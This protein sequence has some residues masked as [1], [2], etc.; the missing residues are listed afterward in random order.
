[1]SKSKRRRHSEEFK[2][3]AVKLVTE[4][5]YSVAKAARNLGVHVNLLRTWQRKFAA[6]ATEEQDLTEEER[7][8][9]A[10]LRTENKRL[11]MERDILKK[12]NGLLRERE[13]LRF[14]FIE[15][16]CEEWP[17]TVMCK[18]LEVSR[19]GFSAWRKRA[20]SR[21][22]ERQRTW[23]SEMQQIHSDRDMKSY[24]S[25]RMQQELVARGDDLSENTVAKPRRR[26][27]P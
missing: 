15:Q 11:R 7:M 18:V 23:V 24:G 9:L 16:H 2:Q 12:S 26:I 22:A 21:R 1:M 8:E 6:E 25:P 13:A 19:S 27:L 3:E 20:E 14:E 17:I 4:Q 10:R 5:Q